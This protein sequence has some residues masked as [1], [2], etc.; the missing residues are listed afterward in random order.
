MHTLESSRAYNML[1]VYWHYPSVS[2]LGLAGS[3][4]EIN[5]ACYEAALASLVLSIASSPAATGCE[6]EGTPDGKYEAIDFCAL[7]S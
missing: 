6:D 4:Y 5:S 1:M 7:A 3:V 2:R